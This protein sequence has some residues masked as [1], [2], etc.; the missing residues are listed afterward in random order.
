M[1]WWM[2]T[3][4]GLI[5]ILFG[6][7]ALT[8]PAITLTALT[9]LFGAYALLDGIVSLLS[10]FHAGR[11]HQ[12]WWP[13]MLEGIAGILAAGMTVVWPALTLLILLY[14]IA[15]WAI[16]T[17]I[18]EL[19]AAF[20]LRHLIRHEWLLWL[21]GASSIFLGVALF[22]APAAGAIVIAWWM[23]AYA[24]VFGVL[25]LTLSFRLRH[26]TNTSSPARAFP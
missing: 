16:V 20:Q 3:I 22:G 10:A 1:N 19:A 23:G 6:V 18:F 12:R 17:G 26:W 24:L 5:A 4:R 8:Q 7:I 14:L 9:L 15:A 2:L 11:L 21:A 25:I 13:F